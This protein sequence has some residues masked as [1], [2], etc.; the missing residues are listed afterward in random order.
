MTYTVDIYKNQQVVVLQIDAVLWS[1]SGSDSLNNLISA[2]SVVSNRWA[3]SILGR[4]YISLCKYFSFAIGFHAEG[5]SLNSQIYSPS[6]RPSLVERPGRSDRLC[7]PFWMILPNESVV[8][9]PTGRHVPAHRS[10]SCA[11]TSRESFV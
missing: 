9:V 3:D 11:S 7:S 4:P 5:Q 6:F 2:E 1:N 8:V 10:W